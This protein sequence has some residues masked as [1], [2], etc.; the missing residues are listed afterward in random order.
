MTK[1]VTFCHLE[2]A[3]SFLSRMPH[4]FRGLF[5]Y[6]AKKQKFSSFSCSQNL[7]NTFGGISKIKTPLGIS[8]GWNI[9]ITTVI[10]TGKVFKFSFHNIFWSDQK[11]ISLFFFW[12]DIRNSSLVGSLSIFILKTHLIG[13]SK[14]KL[15]VILCKNIR[16]KC[17]NEN[18]V[19]DKYYFPSLYLL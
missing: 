18:N 17:T 11:I 2:E 9:S 6:S 8:K 10:S 13:L 19:K 7:I 14:Q 4:I 1:I 15:E 12:D 3:F 16:N 5:Y